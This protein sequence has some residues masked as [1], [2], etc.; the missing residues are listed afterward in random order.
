MYYLNIKK[1][2]KVETVDSTDTLKEAKRLKKEYIIASNYY[3]GLYISSRPC[4]EWGN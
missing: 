4:K 3:N 2:G 1:D